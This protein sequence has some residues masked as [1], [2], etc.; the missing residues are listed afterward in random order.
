MTNTFIYLA[1]MSNLTWKLNSLFW[2]I[3]SQ[4]LCKFYYSIWPIL[5]PAKAAFE[6]N[7]TTAKNSWKFV[8]KWAVSLLS[9]D[10]S[11]LRFVDNHFKI[12]LSRC[13]KI[14]ELNLRNV[15]LTNNS[16]TIIQEH[17]SHTLKKLSLDYSDELSLIGFLELKSMPRLKFLF[18]HDDRDG[19][20]EDRDEAIENL[21]KQLPHL[22]I[23]CLFGT[24]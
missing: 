21:R 17:L 24:Q 20:D 10:I 18:F 6:N 11:S 9:L 14:K 23:K 13:N 19:E 15:E 2:V 4:N 1:K 8:I 7:K 12:L 3:L 16:L 5:C 22:R